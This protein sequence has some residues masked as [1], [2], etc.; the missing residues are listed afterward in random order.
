MQFSDKYRFKWTQSATEINYMKFKEGIHL[1][2]HISNAYK[3]MATKTSTLEILEQLNIALQKGE[4]QS[5]YIKRVSDFFPETYQ[6]G[7]VADL[8]KFLNSK[9]GG[10]WI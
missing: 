7:V 1:V 10:M 2:N 3:L 6:L 5:E 4:L 8:V 9:T